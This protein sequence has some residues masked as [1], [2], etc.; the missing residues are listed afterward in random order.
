MR[1]YR[2]TAKC[3]FTPQSLMC[4]RRRNLAHVRNCANVR[5]RAR[6]RARGIG[7]GRKE[8]KIAIERWATCA[9]ATMSLDDP[10]RGDPRKR[11]EMKKG[12]WAR[13]DAPD[14]H[15]YYWQTGYSFGFVPRWPRV[16][17]ISRAARVLLSLPP[18][19]SRATR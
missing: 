13:A 1:V 12:K 2:C 3:I 7:F 14:A 8:K 15:Y 6:A 4:E 16:I 11:N 10:A 9:S 19:P 18:P 17:V 5:M